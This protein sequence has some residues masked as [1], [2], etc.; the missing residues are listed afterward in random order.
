MWITERVTG[1]VVTCLR[2]AWT[3]LL[4]PEEWQVS[5]CT[6]CS[7]NLK[8]LQKMTQFCAHQLVSLPVNAL[9]RNFLQ[10]MLLE[11][12]FYNPCAKQGNDTKCSF[13]G[14][15]T[16]FHQYH[17][18]R[19][20]IQ[21][22]YLQQVTHSLFSLISSSN[23]PPWLIPCWHTPNI[24]LIFKLCSLRQ[25]YA[26]LSKEILTSSGNK[27]SLKKHNPHKDLNSIALLRSDIQDYGSC[28][29]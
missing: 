27:S 9:G 23:P 19:F 16:Q 1:K 14:R 22:N 7:S 29:H 3:M 20:P 21:W 25:W 11:D 13:C 26:N 5:K 6:G 10:T 17:R 18:I 12:S 15:V 24:C 28:S 4:A 2:W 8:Y